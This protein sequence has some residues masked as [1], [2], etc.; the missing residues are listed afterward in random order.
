MR[1]A[2]GGVWA[3][4]LTPFLDDGGIDYNGLEQ[5]IEW[6]LEHRVAGL[7]AVCKSSESAHMTRDERV[8]I[9]RFVVKR[10]RGRVPVIAG[11]NLSDTLPEQAREMQM[12]ADAGV[13]AVVVLTSNVVDQGASG[14]EWRASMERLLELVPEDMQ[15]GIYESP[16]PY[17]LILDRESLAW[18]RETDRFR[19][20]KDTSCSANAITEKLETVRDSSLR[21]FNAHTQTLLH[22]L[23]LGAAG[24]SSVMA[25][26]NPS[27]YD[28][29]IHNHQLEPD[30][31]ERLQWFLTVADAATVARCYPASAKYFL[32]L[33]GVPLSLFTRTP[34]RFPVDATMKRTMDQLWRLNQEYLNAYGC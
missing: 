20:L 25:N 18:C 1:E 26:V 10:T 5:L 17:H 9:A 33:E 11:G 21:V 13:D 28:W 34:T 23:R 19:F 12:I 32:T 2:P 31:A 6:Y 30:R 24:Y 3:T 16:S 29:L 27:L 22:S 14:Q 8:S 4:M 15:L 7:F